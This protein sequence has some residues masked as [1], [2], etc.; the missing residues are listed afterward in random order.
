MP[1]TC[2]E[3]TTL[4]QQ[5]ARDIH[6]LQQLVV[7]LLGMQ[8]K[9]HRAACVGGVRHMPMPLHQ[10]PRQEAIDG[11]KAQLARPRAVAHVQRVQQPLQLGS[12]EIGIGHQAGLF[13]GSF[14]HGHP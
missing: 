13:C 5:L 2:E 3:S 6:D 7:P 10:M 1:I 14:R 4:R 12:R 11:A 8:I 9:Q